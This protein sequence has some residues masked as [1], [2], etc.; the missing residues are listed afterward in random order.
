MEIHLPDP[1]PGRCLNFRHDTG[2]AGRLRRCLEMEGTKHV[3]RFDPPAP[4][5]QAT[6]SYTLTEP[7]QRPW[8]VPPP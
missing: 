4:S 7:R 8:K 2:R 1:H 3:C 6:H 5:Q